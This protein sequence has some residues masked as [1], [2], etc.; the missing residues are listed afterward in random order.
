MLFF[1]RPSA[2]GSSS[3]PSFA[4]AGFSHTQAQAR[5]LRQPTTLSTNAWRAIVTVNNLVARGDILALTSRS[6]IGYWP[7]LG[8]PILPSGK[9]DQGSGKS[10]QSPLTLFAVSQGKLI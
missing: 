6:K 4:F 7:L 9:R 5:L 1:H 8:I 3:A 2:F 10:G